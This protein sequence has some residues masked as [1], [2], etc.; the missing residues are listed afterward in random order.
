MRYLEIKGM[1]E[2]LQKQDIDVSNLLEMV[3]ALANGSEPEVLTNVPAKIK[4]IDM[5]LMEKIKDSLNKLIVEHKNNESPKIKF[6]IKELEKYV[7]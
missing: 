5:N 3:N 2:V 7:S 4:Y 6:C 1:L